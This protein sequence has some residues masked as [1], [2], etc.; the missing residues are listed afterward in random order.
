MHA[1]PFSGSADKIYKASTKRKR[2]TN[3]KKSPDDDTEDDV[4]LQKRGRERSGVDCKRESGGS[5]NGKNSEKSKGKEKLIKVKDEPESDFSSTSSDFED[6]EDEMPLAKLRK[7]GLG[8]FHSSSKPYTSP[9]SDAYANG[10]MTPIPGAKAV[11]RSMAGFE[12]G[13]GE[14]WTNALPLRFNG[15]QLSSAKVAGVSGDW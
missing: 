15:H 6:S 11:P 3:I 1:T 5:G 2:G 12:Y 4:S 7:A 10:K 13:M 8:P 9:Y 14:E